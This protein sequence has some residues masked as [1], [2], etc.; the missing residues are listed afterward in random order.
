MLH[1]LIADEETPAQGDPTVTG[2]LT[3]VCF[4]VWVL[5]MSRKEW[6]RCGQTTR[7]NI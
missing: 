3:S 2:S 5:S 1:T 4:L 6:A 7:A